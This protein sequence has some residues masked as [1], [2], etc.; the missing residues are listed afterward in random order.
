[1]INIHTV[2]DKSRGESM[3]KSKLEK[4][5]KQKLELRL[6]L[7]IRTCMDIQLVTKQAMLLFSCL[8]LLFSF[9]LHSDLSI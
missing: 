7:M 8:I 1:M 2:E 3:K 4:Q 5:M 9:T 6:A